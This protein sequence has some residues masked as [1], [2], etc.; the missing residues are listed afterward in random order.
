MSEPVTV[1]WLAPIDGDGHN[2]NINN[3]TTTYDGYEVPAAL[4][5]VGDT[6]EPHSDFALYSPSMGTSYANWLWVYMDGGIYYGSMTDTTLST[7]TYYGVLTN[8]TVFSGC[9]LMPACRLQV[10][11]GGAW[12]FGSANPGGMPTAAQV[13]D[14]VEFAGGAL[15]GEYPTTATTQAASIAEVN[16]NV[17]DI[18]LGEVVLTGADA[19]TLPVPRRI[20]G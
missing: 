15:T 16:G 9:I 1:Y 10:S 2:E 17:A 5:G 14:A 7:G 8:C 19:G 4:P 6:V 13:E 20:I 18:K 3:Y 11:L 12:L